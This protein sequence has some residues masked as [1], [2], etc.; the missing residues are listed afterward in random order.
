MTCLGEVLFVVMSG[1][2][3]TSPTLVS[4]PHCFLFKIK[5]KGL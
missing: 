5:D 3:E 1:I 4:V 2:P